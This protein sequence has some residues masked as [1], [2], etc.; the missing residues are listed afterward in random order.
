MKNISGK[1]I[2]VKMNKTVVVVIDRQ[3]IHPMYKKIVRRNTKVKAHHDNLKINKG[4][5]VEI[6]S[7]RPISK[8][9][10]YKVIKVL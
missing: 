5:V 2:S 10:H 9:K 8:D 4:D 3:I 1:V 6:S 7:C